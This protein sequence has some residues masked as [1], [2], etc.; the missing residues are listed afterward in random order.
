MY[1]ATKPPW[2]NNFIF[3][4][5]RAET[6]AMYSFAIACFFSCNGLALYEGREALQTKEN[7]VKPQKKYHV[8]RTCVVSKPTYLILDFAFILRVAV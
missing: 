3:R 1:V 7:V 2:E 8:S 5:G 6:L 4:G